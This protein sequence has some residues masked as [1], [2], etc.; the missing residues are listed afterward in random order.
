MDLDQDGASVTGTYRPGD[1]R[2]EA[3]ADGRILEGR[4][5]EARA[6]GRFR[7]LMAADGQT[8]SGVD[9]RGGYW[10]GGRTDAESRPAP[11]LGDVRTASGAL[12]T[13][14]AGLN[15]TWVGDASAALVWD[16]LLAF[17]GPETTALDQRYRRMMLFWL[18]DM[19]T[20]QAKWI[21]FSTQPDTA[22]LPVGPV[23]STWRFDLRM[24]R[25]ADG[26]WQLVVPPV[27][28]LAET[29]DDG[30]AATG[31][32]S[33]DAFRAARRTGPR[34]TM[35]SFLENVGRWDKGGREAAL[36]ALD[37]SYL[38]PHLRDV[39]G[40]VLADYLR[41]VIDRAGY[42]IWQEIPDDPDHAAPYVHY[43]HPAGTIEIAPVTV[44]PPEG[45][46]ELPGRAWK[47]SRGTL[48]SLPALHA[49]TQ[50]MAIAEGLSPPEPL[51][52]FFRTRL[53]FEQNR[54][55]LVERRLGLELWQWAAVAATAL[56]TFLAVVGVRWILVLIGRLPGLGW[57]PMFDW[58][59][60]ILALGGVLKLLVTY[61]GLRTDL[62]Q[63]IEAMAIL[64][65]I[66]GTTGL[67]FQL[68][69]PIVRGMQ[70]LLQRRG[71][72][73]D[74]VA[75]LVTGLLKFAV[76]LVG[77]LIAADTMGLPYEGVVAGLGGGG[78]RRAVRFPDPNPA[79]GTGRR[80]R[81]IGGRGAADGSR[82][83]PAGRDRSGC[84]LALS[85]ELDQTAVVSGSQLSH[86]A[87]AAVSQ[88]SKAAA[89][90]R[91]SVGREIR[92]RWRW[93]VL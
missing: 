88:A 44:P 40:A 13:V 53:W 67:V 29:L 9:D 12:R 35:R 10:N 33:Y 14:M 19:A 34:Q 11:T 46:Q 63:V 1:G 21:E 90:K 47:F 20:F 42:V 92:W 38:P 5:V 16:P 66:S 80:A 74:I 23:D 6:E 15:R 26:V 45:S 81:F 62:A 51:S 56:G 41:Q 65:L 50:D 57:A 85:R 64:A 87:S 27:N 24:E 72:S 59:F 49:A 2:I 36:A 28:E 48:Q 30:L 93:K 78:N 4:W 58:P 55:I 18:M 84:R 31:H 8:F 54:P 73:D 3:V 79:H 25:G 75:A 61:A 17:E 69:G 89:R 82:L 43:R 60:R 76:V 71:V 39:E 32:E 68:V 91:R 22:I 52:R 70:W 86:A 37:L 83:R 77:I 7:F